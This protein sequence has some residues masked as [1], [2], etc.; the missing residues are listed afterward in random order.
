LRQVSAA[1]SSLCILKLVGASLQIFGHRIISDR[2]LYARDFSLI[3]GRC[4]AK[5]KSEAERAWR[6]AGKTQSILPLELIYI[7]DL[8]Q[9]RVRR[10]QPDAIHHPRAR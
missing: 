4:H 5:T 3:A 2:G 8:H 1:T 9:T 6:H 7:F 10:A